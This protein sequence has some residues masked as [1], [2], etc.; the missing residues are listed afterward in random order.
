MV[1]VV[2]ALHKMDAFAEG[3]GAKRRS[4]AEQGRRRET[5]LKRRDS[6]LVV[7]IPSFQL[8]QHPDLDLARIPVFLDGANDLDSV[9]LPRRPVDG[10][11]DLSEGPFSELPND[12]IWRKRRRNKISEER[13]RLRERKRDEQ[14]P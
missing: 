10:L 8:V 6:L 9:V 2:K 12:S 11:D 7:R 14:R 4:A 1:L 3:R 5:K 13:R